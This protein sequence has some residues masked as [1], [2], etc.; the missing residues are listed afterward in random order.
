[1][2]EQEN[3]FSFAKFE[4]AKALRKTT[5]KRAANELVM[6]EILQAEGGAMKAIDLTN[7]LVQHFNDVERDSQVLCKQIGFAPDEIVTA[8]WLV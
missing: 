3:Q 4:I 8:A 6:L 1:M 2:P 5:I 7:R